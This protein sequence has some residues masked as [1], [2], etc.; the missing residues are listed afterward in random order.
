MV[1]FTL[2]QESKLHK[3]KKEKKLKSQN[4]EQKFTS[5]LKK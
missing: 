5:D 1:N 4:L 2:N 3:L